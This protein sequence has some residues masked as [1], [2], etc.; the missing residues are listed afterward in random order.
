LN[1]DFSRVIVIG[2]TGSGKTTLAKTLA[3]ILECPHIEVD[4]LY[5]GPDWRPKPID[6]F[7]RLT[8]QAT[9]QERWVLDGNHRAVRDL[10]WPRVTMVVWLNYGFARVVYSTFVRSLRRARSA[11]EVHS[12]SRESIRHAF[13]SRGSIFWLA[14]RSFHRRRRRHGKEF[15]TRGLARAEWVE[16]RKPSEAETF[17]AGVKNRKAED[18]ITL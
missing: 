1:R 2:S 16:F 6:Q 10:I 7:R 12:G 17:L 14:I 13:F 5:W 18:G 11:E 15:R 3:R 9:L 8:E 4:D